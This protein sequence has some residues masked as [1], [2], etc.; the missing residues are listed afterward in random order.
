M[1]L[2]QKKAAESPSLISLLSI[3]EID[4]GQRCNGVKGK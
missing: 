2:V 3:N 1:G 4:V